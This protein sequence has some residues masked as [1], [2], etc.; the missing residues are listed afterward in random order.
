MSK[1]IFESGPVAEI[2]KQFAGKPTIFKGYDSLSF[3]GAKV[4]AIAQNNELK[5][6]AASGEAIVL[7]DQTPFYGESGGQVGDK[8]WLIFTGGDPASKA[9]TGHRVLDTQKQE[10]LFL[11]RVELQGALKVGE[12]VTAEVDPLHRAPTLKN[13]SATHLLHNA[14]RGILGTHVE[15]RGSLVSPD[16]LRFDFTHFEQI[17]PEQ[18][19]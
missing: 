3:S 11:H 9:K 19:S 6:E 5:S 14:L 12:L 4:L 15:Q 1:E 7:L 17:K 16:R 13:H 10:G 18:L 8:G 2:K